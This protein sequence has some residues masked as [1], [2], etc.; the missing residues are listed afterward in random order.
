MRIAIDIDD[1]ITNTW[2]S[3][4]PAACEYFKI[5]EQL[6]RNNGKAYNEAIGCTL[7]E[8]YTFARKKFES[9]VPYLDLKENAVNVIN[10]L[11]EDGHEIIILTARGSND[12]KNPYQ[13]SYDY[14]TNKGILFD[15]LIVDGHDKG[16][17]CKKEKIDLLIDDSIK[18]CKGTTDY[19]I[20][21][22]LFDA[23][24]NKEC[25]EFKRVYNWNE[26]YEYIKNK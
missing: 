24:H 3:I 22:L 7:D 23:L 15:K 17:I 14:L 5:D 16:I 8:W 21:V 4:I 20:D 13:I 18:K 9:I 26:V 19:G 10:K 12:Y 6:L 11:K 25:N 2:K 1:T